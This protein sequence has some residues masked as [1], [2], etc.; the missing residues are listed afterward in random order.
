MTLVNS[1]THLIMGAALFGKPLPRLAWAGAAGGFAPDLPMYVI[2]SGLRLQGHSLDRIFSRFYWQDFWQIAN[3]IGHNFLLWGSLAIISAWAVFANKRTG[4]PGNAA[5]GWPGLTFAF[6]ASALLHSAIDFLTHR[7]DAHMHF[8][9]LSDWRFR[10]PVSYWDSNHYGTQFS[11]FE[12]ALGIA[13]AAI[14]MRRYANP[15]IRL[16]LALCVIAYAAVPVF[17]Y[18]SLSSHD[19]NAPASG[20]D[21]SDPRYFTLPG[22][23]ERPRTL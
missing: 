15:L 6:S 22:Q 17:Y 10:S 5:G 14:L 12:A 1:Q 23:V 4:N 7:D 8:W 9:P 2:V 21:S 11:L 20:T 16:A 3:A 13:I 18:W 19:H